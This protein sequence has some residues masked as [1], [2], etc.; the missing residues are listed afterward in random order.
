MSLF[1]YLFPKYLLKELI[2]F[3]VCSM[4]EWEAKWKGDLFALIDFSSKM[5][6]HSD[7]I[8]IT[9]MLHY[10]KYIVYLFKIIKYVYYYIIHSLNYFL[11]D[12]E[13]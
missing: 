8:I 7:F 13:Y 6:R 4:C 11:T 12:V 10:K 5:L 9:L 2:S 1:S 3:E